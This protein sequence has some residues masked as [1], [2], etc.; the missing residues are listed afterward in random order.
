MLILSADFGTTSLKLAVLDER[1]NILASRRLEYG[2]TI[3]GG[4][5]VEIEAEKVLSAFIR[6]VRSLDDYA[7]KIEALSPCTFCPS[8]VAMDGE[9]KSLFPVITHLDRRSVEQARRALKIVGKDAFL[10]INGN[11]PF[12]GG[13]SLTSILWLRD[14]HPEIYGKTRVFGHFNTY[15]HRAIAGR[16]VIE[17]TNAS[18]TGLY[19]TLKWGGWSEKLCGALGVD[20]RKLPEI[21]L[22]DALAGGLTKNAAALTGLREGIP[23]VMGAND[24]SSA[25]YGA[26]VVDNG[27][28]L[29]I[30]GSNEIITIALDRPLVHE[31]MYLRTHVIRGKW[32][33]LAITAGGGALEWFRREFCR[34]MSSEAFY[35][36]YLAEFV[37][38]RPGGERAGDGTGEGGLFPRAGSGVHF[39]PY[40]AGDRHRIE[41]RKASFRG[42]TLASRRE[43]FLQAILEGI[44]EPMRMV[45]DLY[46]VKVDLKREIALTGGLAGSVPLGLKERMFGNYR[47]RSVPEAAALGNGKLALDALS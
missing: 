17:P 45:L 23:V 31:K 14:T 44:L 6:G 32:L 16:F 41:Q 18:F 13:I 36:E 15:L 38:R 4:G 25:A 21:E 35:G 8:L 11:L 24:S 28:I 42:I 19:E 3:E 39:S 1:L 20:A 30:S 34:E 47:F 12:P 37:R 29:N 40:L 43:D 26:G 10:D 33:C 2:C 5:R 22:S 7:E 27:S 9:G 46:G